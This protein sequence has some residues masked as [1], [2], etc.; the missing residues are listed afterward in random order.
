LSGVHRIL[1]KLKTS[2]IKVGVV[3]PK[4]K[5]PTN[6]AFSYL[7]RNG[8]DMYELRQLTMTI[9]KQPLSSVA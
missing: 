6:I 2:L 5:K 9:I 7:D 4:N 8:K 3:E 1:R